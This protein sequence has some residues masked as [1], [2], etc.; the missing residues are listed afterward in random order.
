MKLTHKARRGRPTPTVVAKPCST[1]GKGGS[2]L[3]TENEL[4]QE[5]ALLTY[6]LEH[7][8]LRQPQTDCISSAATVLRCRLYSS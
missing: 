7:S 8:L 4:E 2:V 3:F 1:D 5:E 6:D